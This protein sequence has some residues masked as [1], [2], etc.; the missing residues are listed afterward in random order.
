VEKKL[1]D[2]SASVRSAA[3]EAAT[4]CGGQRAVPVL[5]LALKDTSWE[6]RRAAAKALG[7]IGENSAVPGLCE[8]VQ[9]PD[10]DVRETVISA[11]GQINDIRALV[12]LVTALLDVERVVRSLA[13]ATLRKLKKDWEQSEQMKAALPAIQA[14]LSHPDYWVRYSA[15][16]LLEQLKI[17]VDQ[18]TDQLTVTPT[19]PAESAVPHVALPFLADLLFDR[20]RDLRVA[21]A[22]ALGRLR[23]RGAATVLAA[24]ARDADHAVQHAAQA[25]LSALN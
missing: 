22:E 2:P 13:Q 9:D 25:A 24:A 5:L 7:F 15:T 10:R 18:L 17:D 4:R 16:Q 21:A 3:V 12:P 1:K 20:D 19:A 8:L 6:V 14:A 23:E 11:L